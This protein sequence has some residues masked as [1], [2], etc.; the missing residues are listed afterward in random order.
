MDSRTT[1]KT[2]CGFKNGSQELGAKGEMGEDF[3]AGS[4]QEC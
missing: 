1:K 4:W 3:S 2:R